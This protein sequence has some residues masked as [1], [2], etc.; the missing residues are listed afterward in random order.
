MRGEKVLECVGKGEKL[1]ALVRL[2][3][4]GNCSVKFVRQRQVGSGDQREPER[5]SII[6]CHGNEGTKARG[7]RRGCL[8]EDLLLPLPRALLPLSKTPWPSESAHL[9]HK[10]VTVKLSHGQAKHG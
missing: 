2:G 6:S 3:E 5:R 10:S 1:G 4:A 9:Q 7:R 8:E